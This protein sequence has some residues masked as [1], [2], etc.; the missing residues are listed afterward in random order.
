MPVETNIRAQVLAQPTVVVG[1]PTGPSGGPTGPTGPQ[2]SVSVTG[3]TG[4]VG[5]TGPTGST[6]LTGAPGLDG[7][8]TGPTGSTG[9]AGSIAATGPTGPTGLPAID[10]SNP[11]DQNFPRVYSWQDAGNADFITGVDTIERMLG[12]AFGFSPMI[13]GN[14]LVIITGTAEN[15]D[16]GGTT[17][18]AR[19][20]VGGNY[21]VR[22]DPVTGIAFG[23]PV[24]TYAPGLSIPFT[25]VGI[26]QLDVIPIFSYP[27]FQDYWFNV[28]VKSTIGSGA[29]VHTVTYTFMEL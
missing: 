15:T 16:N 24:E 10:L 4:P 23:T 25:I 8:L 21:P 6:G 3:A 5:S 9:P 13:T 26:A 11:P 19:Y 22:G 14:V 7:I 12:T 18:T 28:S 2:G 29:G 17:V 20:D 1:G 27:Y